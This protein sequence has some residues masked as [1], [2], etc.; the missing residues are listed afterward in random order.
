MKTAQQIPLDLGHR[1]ALG[2]EDFL[3]TES[4]FDAVSWIDLWPDWPAPALILYGPAACGKSH[5]AEVWKGRTG[6][7]DADLESA[8]EEDLAASGNHLILDDI[9]ALLGERQAETRLFHL[10]NM[11]KEAQRNILI[12][13]RTAPVRVPFAVPDL[14]SRLRACPAVAIQ[15]PDDAL[16]AAVLVKLFSDRQLAIGQDVLNYI[17]PRM[18]RSFAAARDLVEA[19]DRAALS[20][21]RR[22]TIPLMRD[23]MVGQA[24]MTGDS[25]L[26]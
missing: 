12:T 1:A 4:N 10:Y 17:L 3:V 23:V 16:L 6:A 25:V 22:I 21:K 2:R 26:L 11:M 5:L 24:D 13:I 18:E 7:Q 8:S 19:A 15:P 20:E 9:D 14:A